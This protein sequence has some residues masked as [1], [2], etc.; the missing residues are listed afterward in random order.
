MALAALLIPAQVWCAF[1]A[2]VPPNRGEV[3]AAEFAEN[4]NAV[5]DY[6]DYGLW[7]NEE[8]FELADQ[9]IR[10]RYDGGPWEERRYGEPVDDVPVYTVETDGNGYVTAVCIEREGRFSGEEDE[11]VRL[12]AGDMAL[13]IMTAFRGAWCSGYDALRGPVMEALEQDMELWDGRPIRDG[14]FTVTI[15]LEQQGYRFPAG[16]NLFLLRQEGTAERWYRFALRLE[17]TGAAD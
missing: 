14:A 5:A 6:L 16:S 15:T 8:G 4:V 9:S 17:R 12:P 11:H 2:I 13:V 1:Q 7:V 3:T 10:I